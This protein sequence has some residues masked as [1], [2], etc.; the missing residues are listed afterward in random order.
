EDEAE[1]ANRREHRRPCPDD[2]AGVAR[3]QPSPLRPALPR[4]E[5]AV[6]DGYRATQAST[7]PLDELMREG[8]LGDKQRDAP[9]SCE[10]V[11]RCREKDLG[12]SAPGAAMQQEG[13]RRG[14]VEGRVQ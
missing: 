14:G 5:A 10:R 13:R 1:A 12:L 3:A 4:A 6:Q 7:D 11:L 9:T 2:D 8:D